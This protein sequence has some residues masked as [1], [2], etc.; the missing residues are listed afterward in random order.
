MEGFN[1]KNSS[2]DEIRNY[3]S[4]QFVSFGEI[5]RVNVWRLPKNKSSSPSTPAG[6]A[7]V[8]FQ[9]T[10]SVEQACREF[11][12]DQTA[13]NASELVAGTS[14]QTIVS[15]KHLRVLPKEKWNQHRNEYLR[16]QKKAAEEVN[17]YWESNP[18]LPTENPEVVDSIKRSFD[19]TANPFRQTPG[20]IVQLD[21]QASSVDK[22]GST[23]ELRKRL[24]ELFQCDESHISEREVAC[25]DVSESG[26]EFKPDGSV[27]K[28]AF[29]RLLRLESAS[30]LIEDHFKQHFDHHFKDSLS[31]AGAARIL[32][33]AQTEEYWKTVNEVKLDKKVKRQRNNFD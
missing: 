7:F 13:E 1:F 9:D 4:Q 29:I 33:T 23:M 18:M 24:R 31:F 28:Q 32:D 27:H 3:L 19:L 2:V 10:S 16:Q 6:F 22:L 21:I 30:K 12:W 15:K 25:I 8:E 14:S 26:L 5:S 17:A 20:L 11:E